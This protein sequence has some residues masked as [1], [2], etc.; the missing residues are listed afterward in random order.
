MINSI[1]LN[2]LTY[3]YMECLIGIDLR[4]IFLRRDKKLSITLNIHKTDILQ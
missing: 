4:N 1:T 3:M 2:K